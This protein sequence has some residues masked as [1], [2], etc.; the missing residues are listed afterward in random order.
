MLAIAYLGARPS[1]VEHL[2]NEVKR[3]VRETK[4]QIKTCNHWERNDDQPTRKRIFYITP[5]FISF[6]SV[7]LRGR[8]CTC[9]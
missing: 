5:S 9:I 2:F 1:D 8:I 3:L 4:N 7:L 6:V